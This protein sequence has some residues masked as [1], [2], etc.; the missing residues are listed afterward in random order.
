M[1]LG[2]E[3]KTKLWLTVGLAMVAVYLGITRLPSMFSAPPQTAAPVARSTGPN[4][5]AVQP[6]RRPVGRKGTRVASLLTPTLDPRLR[7]DLLKRSETTEY[8]G[9]GRNIFRAEAEPA[10]IPKPIVPPMPGP[11]GNTVGQNVPPTPPPPPPIPLKFFGIASK[12]GEPKRALLADGD[13]VFIAK[14]GDIVD[15]HYKINKIGVNSVEIQDVL[16]NN[17]QTIPLTAQG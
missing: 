15:R 13:D 8:T 7:L 17:V 5:P 12:P 9:A 14:E 11:G 6:V 10:P 16:T 4:I 1:K 2:A 3:N